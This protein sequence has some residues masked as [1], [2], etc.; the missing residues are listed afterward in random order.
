MPK[1]AVDTEHRPVSR[2]D[3]TRRQWIWKEMKRNKVA[4]LMVGPFMVLFFIFTILPVA[5]SIVFSLTD[6]NMLQMPH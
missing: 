6:F 3:L 5:L 2:Q 1:N 4:Y